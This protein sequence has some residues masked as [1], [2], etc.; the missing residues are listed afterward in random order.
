M[1][2]DALDRAFAGCGLVTR[3]GFHP[4]PAERLPTGQPTGTLVLIGNVG[5]AMWTAFSAACDPASRAALAHPLDAWTRA[6]V[7]PV[8]LAFGAVP[9]YPFEGPPFQPFQRWARRALP[10]HE[11]P[12]GPLID[13]EAG[14]WHALR[15]ALVF[16]E[17]LPLPRPAARPNPCDTCADRPCLA[18][19]PVDAIGRDR[20]DVPA[21]VGHVNSPAGGDCRHGGCRARLACPVGARFRYPPEQ[22][23]FHMAKFLDAHDTARPPA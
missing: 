7:D 9:L 10:V 19:C 14:L 1:I 17:L 8:A 18:G 21:C 2:L 3:G 11:S 15:A 13:A 6:V 20:Y 16:R 12:I 5:G 4:G 23:R 22:R